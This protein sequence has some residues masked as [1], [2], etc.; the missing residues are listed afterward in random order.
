MDD[1]IK[2]QASASADW[3]P[4]DGSGMPVD[5]AVIIDAKLRSGQIVIGRRADHFAW[6]LIFTSTDII[7]YRIAKPVTQESAE[8]RPTMTDLMVSPESIGDLPDT[9]QASAD[10]AMDGTFE[11]DNDHVRAK[12]YSENDYK[13]LQRD[14]AELRKELTA[15]TWAL[16]SA[17][18]HNPLEDELAAL[19]KTLSDS[20]KGL[21]E[22][23]DGDVCIPSDLDVEE[24]WKRN[25]EHVRKYHYDALRAAAQERIE[26]ILGALGEHIDT[27]LDVVLSGIERLRH[28]ARRSADYGSQL[29]KA[30]ERIAIL[31]KE[32]EAMRFIAAEPHAIAKVHAEF[33]PLSLW[34]K[35][36]LEDH[37]REKDERIAGLEVAFR[38]NMLRLR[39]EMSHAEIDAVIAS[40]AK[41][42]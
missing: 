2:E 5:R 39:P 42:S 33:G 1:E 35:K 14:N 34:T 32:L 25:S 23:P 3:I 16:E 21:P 6:G 41:Q 20:G 19:R 29:F 31:S 27:D 36:G 8:L 26:S 37:D 28:E 38:V 10:D 4:Y 18:A 22:L 24:L 17:N 9:T 11:L 30:Q 7:A 40:A 12:L 15:T 13:S